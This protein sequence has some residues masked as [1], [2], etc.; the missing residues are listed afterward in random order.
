MDLLERFKAYLEEVLLI[1]HDDRVLLAVSGG[2]DSM[3]M[4][5]LFKESGYDIAIAHCNFQ[6]RGEASDL[7]EA[8][9]K[10]FA[11]GNAIPFFAKR[12]DTVA[13]A[14]ENGISIQMAARELRYQWFEELRKEVQAKWIAVAQHQNDHIET[15]LLN[16]TRG[17]G[18]QGLQG[19]LPKRE[20]IIRPLL[21]L[22][23]KEIAQF[24]KAN[25]IPFRDDA[26]NFSTKYARNKIRLDIIPKFKEITPDFER[27]FL[28]NIRHFQESHELLQ[29]FISPIREQLFVKRED[30][31]EIKKD[32]IAPY[33]NNMP[34]MFELFKPYGFSKAILQDL[35]GNWQGV[36][37]KVFESPSY[38]LLLDRE[39][40]Y[41]KQDSVEEDDAIVEIYADTSSVVFGGHVFSMGITDDLCLDGNPA[42]AKLDYDKL[43]FPLTLRHWQ[44]GDVFHPLGMQGKKKLSDFFIQQKVPLFEKKNMPLLINGNGDVLWVVHYRIDNRYKIVKSTKKVFTLVCK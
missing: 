4:G 1:G 9:V 37:G 31:V 15:V 41:L 2:K 29:S 40:L 26:S 38:K 7:D 36:S 19:I 34:L 30:V 23:S 20:S 27:V 3:L 11:Q 43:L 42:L 5:F 25:R 33:L 14:Q 17:T 24:V 28:Q 18:L 32:E 44:E 12:F 10:N 39:L 35:R 8:L 6:L 22:N 13:F 21:F 16:L